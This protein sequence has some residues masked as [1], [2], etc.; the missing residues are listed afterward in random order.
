[1]TDETKGDGETW[2][3]YAHRLEQRIKEQRGHLNSL[4]KLGG[5]R[6][7]D[8]ERIAALERLVGRKS[9]T[10]DRHREAVRALSEKVFGMF[11]LRDVQELVALTNG[12]DFAIIGD[13]IPQEVWD[14]LHERRLVTTQSHCPGDDPETG[15]TADGIA[16]VVEKISGR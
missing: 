2:E 5:H 1:M 11:S 15:S 13:A 6:R 10:L 12:G 9:L 16:Y 8:T 4:G 7:R 14:D 3:A